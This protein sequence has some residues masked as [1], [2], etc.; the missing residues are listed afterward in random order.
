MTTY[1][2][3]LSIQGYWSSLKKIIFYLLHPSEMVAN[4]GRGFFEKGIGD[5]EG[6][7]VFPTI[8]DNYRYS[9]T[10]FLSSLLIAFV[11]SII[12]TYITILSVGKWKTLLKNTFSFL[13]ALPDIFII[14]VIQLVTLWIY[15]QTDI[16]LFPIAGAFE[17]V[18]ALPIFTLSILPSLFLYRIMLLMV[19]EEYEKPYVM[20]V[21]GK[22]FNGHFIFIKHIFRNSLI[23]V[24]SH[25]KPLVWFMLSNL[26]IMERLFNIYGITHFILEYPRP[27]ILAVSLILFYIPIFFLLLLCQFFIN[28]HT[29]REVVL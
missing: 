13:E 7:S 21:K 1:Q 15:K 6:F 29:G 5:E 10:I 25:I 23:G 27:D 11:T 24:A 18:Y 3:D 12:L 9:L 22:G 16:L 8:W 26:I 4:D 14:F 20:L 19:T 28:R 2:F 17:K